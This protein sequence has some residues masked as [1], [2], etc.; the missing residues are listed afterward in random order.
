MDLYL[1][2]QRS[3]NAFST[4]EPKLLGMFF[5]DDE[6]NTYIQTVA[7]DIVNTSG[8]GVREQRQ[9]KIVLADVGNV[10][11]LYITKIKLGTV[12]APWGNKY[13]GN[14]DKRHSKS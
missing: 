9:D 6:A 3:L 5:S 14:F 2:F 10:T 11:E 1:V 8:M 4:P 12:G 13:E 7:Q